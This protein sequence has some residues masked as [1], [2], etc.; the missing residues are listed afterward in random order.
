MD[1]IE[2]SDLTIALDI[3]DGFILMRRDPKGVPVRFATAVDGN[4]FYR[5]WLDVVT[6]RR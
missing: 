1:G 2:M 6:S 4:R 3:R 5:D